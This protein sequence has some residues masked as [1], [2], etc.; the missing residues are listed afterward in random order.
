MKSANQISMSQSQILYMI[1]K[2]W[3][4]AVIAV[5]A[6]VVLCVPMLVIALIQKLN[7]PL[8]P[9]FFLQNRVGL[10]GKQFRIIKFRTMKSSAP[11]NVSTNDLYNYYEQ[12]TR[13]GRYL[14]R[15]SLDEL[16][17]LV[18]VLKGEMALVGPRPLIPEEEPAQSLRKAY[19]I[20]SIRPGI[21]GLAQISGRDFLDDVEKVRLDRKYLR[22]FG[23]QQ[24]LWILFCSVGCVFRQENVRDT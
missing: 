12:T 22:Q 18:N 23:F 21:T 3:L 10:H 4:D 15:T 14:R 9:V 1:C 19:G 24:D 13:L 5:G 16:P 17:Q 7:S 8:E 20:Y 11:N 6:L 2:R